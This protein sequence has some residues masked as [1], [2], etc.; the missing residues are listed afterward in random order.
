MQKARD[1]A[2]PCGHGPFTACKHAASGTISLPSSGCFSPFP[3]GTCSLSVTRECLAFGHG[4]PG[5][6]RD[7][8]CPVVLGNSIQE[9]SVPFAYGTI[10]LCGRSFQTV[11]LGRRLVTSRGGRSPLQRSPSTPATQR[12]RA[13]TYGRFRLVPFRSPLLWE[14]L[15]LSLPRGTEMFQFPRFASP[16][17]VFSGRYYGI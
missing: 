13:I 14:S 15:L 1:Q 16:A 11:L 7:S 12:L 9:A 4:R 17:Y 8:S 5:F 3:H 6:P 2:C 10:T